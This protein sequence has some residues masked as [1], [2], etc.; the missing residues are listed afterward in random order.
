MR[1]LFVGICCL[2]FLSNL[3][4]QGLKGLYIGTDLG[5]SYRTDNGGDDVFWSTSLGGNA[6]FYLS[7]KIGIGA[8]LN[9]FYSSNVEDN[10]VE[11]YQIECEMLAFRP[12][13]RYYPTGSNADAKIKPFIQILGD[14]RS[15]DLFETFNS[16][17]EATSIRKDR[18][19][20]GSLGV[21]LFLS[22]K[23]FLN[24]Q[25]NFFSIYRLTT[26]SPFNDGLRVIN[27]RYFGLNRAALSLEVMFKL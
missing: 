14:I 3:D 5:V 9:Y 22:E 23:I 17:Y 4:A 24:A 1:S 15:G 19:I 18:G 20:N 26:D 27:A 13:I 6:Q 21:S 10:G 7:P 8:G 12:S 25:S 11:F 16:G 2:I